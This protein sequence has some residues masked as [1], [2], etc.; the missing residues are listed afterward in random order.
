MQ[1]AI[2][3]S[4]REVV[5]FKHTQYNVKQMAI[6]VACA[7]IMAVILLPAGASAQR[8]LELKEM[9]ILNQGDRDPITNEGRGIDIKGNF[10]LIGGSVCSRNGDIKLGEKAKTRMGLGNPD[11][12]T[13]VTLNTSG[14]IS[15]RN[16]AQFDPAQTA[17]TNNL[18]ID[19]T[20]G[21][22]PPGT[23]LPPSEIICPADPPFP[24]LPSNLHL[25]ADVVCTEAGVDIVPGDYRDLIVEFRGKCNFQGPGTYNFRS[26]QSLVSS[27]Y[28][29][30][31]LNGDCDAD[32]GFNINVEKFVR[33][34]E[35]GSV[36]MANTPSVFFN[37][38]GQDDPYDA[39]RL[40][41]ENPDSPFTGQPAV[42]Y[43]GGDGNFNACWVFTPNGTTALHGKS[44][45][46][47]NV[48]WINKYIFEHSTLRIRTK[49]DVDYEKC[50][51]QVFD[52]ACI[53]EFV[54]KA[55][56]DK[57]IQAG[58]TLRIKGKGF[59]TKN[60]E[61]VLFFDVNGSITDL[62]D[63]GASAACYQDIIDF[64]D[65]VTMEVEV[66]IGC[67]LGDYKLG[68]ENSGFCYDIDKILTIV[69]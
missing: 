64:I 53:S 67:A 28:S 18:S 48:Q 22:I 41:D 12:D 69:P 40:D 42:F 17:Y 8:V 20:S 25:A 66:P 50:C 58:A 37:V 1:S 24:S 65:S 19:G 21:I 13:V 27:T 39:I 49:V 29:L 7:A 68:L 52:C 23:V 26:I 59:N 14:V 9:T 32:N 35:Y 44:D 30:N 33:L 4:R 16:F 45:T 36:N 62:S 43:Y 11:F 57:E 46:I 5:M 60:V 61:R 15:L 51:E 54:D 63:P 55:D 56:L 31:F 10:D 38:A 34:K 6:V 2:I 3:R 47:W